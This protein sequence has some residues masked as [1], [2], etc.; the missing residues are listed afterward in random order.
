MMDLPHANG[1]VSTASP[2]TLPID[3]VRFSAVM[4][5]SIAATPNALAETARAAIT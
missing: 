2:G 1:H 5:Q 3:A 4:F